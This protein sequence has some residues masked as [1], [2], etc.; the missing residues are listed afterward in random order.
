MLYWPIFARGIFASNKNE[1]ISPIIASM[2][3]HRNDLGGI[4]E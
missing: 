4:F 1:P 2:L 3:I